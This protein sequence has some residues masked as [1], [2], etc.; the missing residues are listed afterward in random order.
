MMDK[1]KA[2]IEEER[3]NMA[4]FESAVEKAFGTITLA[5]GREAQIQVRIEADE[6]DWM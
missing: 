2:W 1:I 3:K 6:D 5:D 4:P